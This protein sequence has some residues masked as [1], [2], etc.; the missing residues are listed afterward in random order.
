[1]S[2]AEGSDQSREVQPWVR[3]EH[4][5]EPDSCWAAEVPDSVQAAGAEALAV[6]LGM[7]QRHVANMFVESSLRW[8]LRFGG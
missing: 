1:M 4:D 5:Q 6:P 2:L 8:L 7:G 3:E